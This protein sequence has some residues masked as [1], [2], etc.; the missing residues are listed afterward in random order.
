M[1]KGLFLLLS[2][3]FLVGQVLAQ[4]RTINGRVTSADDGQPVIGAT[5]IV[6]GT[7]TG[8]VTNP[9]GAYSI[10]LPDGSAAVLV[11]KS[12]G[13]KELEAKV[14]NS[15]TLNVV[16][17]LDVT[18]LNEQV[19]TANAIRR[20]KSSLGYAAPTVKAEEI[21]QGRATS[22]LSALT[23][24]VAG[25]N[26]TNT[27]GAPGSSSRIV[28]RG[29]S[30]VAG[31]NQALIVV[32]GIPVDNSSVTGGPNNLSSIDF[33]NR[34][35]DINPDDIESMTVL[36]GPAAAALYGSRASNG[37]VIITTKS[38]KKG[39]KKS[40][41]TV[42]STATF[43]NILKLPDFQ[44]EYGQGSDGD[45][46]PK[47]NF[48]WGPKFDG[49][50]KPWGQEID[51]E[52][53]TKP[54][55]AQKNN[56][57]K[58]FELGRAFNNNVSVSGGGEKTTYFLALSS[59]NSDGV[60]PGSSDTYNKYGIRFN[61]SAELSNNFKT[62]VSINYNKINSNMVQG[63]QG[64]GSVYNNLLQTPRD[65]PIDQMGDLNNKFYSY[66]SYVDKNGILRNNRYGYY[67]AYTTSPYYILQN[68]KNLNDVDRVFGN[69]TLTYDPLKWLNVVERV[70]ADVYADRRRFKYPKF[71]LSP[72]DETS[73]NYSQVSNQRNQVG[74]YEE[75]NFNVSEIVHDL[76]I[77][78]KKDFGKDFHASLMVGNN[79]RQ[80][81]TTSLN[82]ATN[83]TGGLVVPEW[84]NL[85]NSNGPV[86]ST[87]NYTI[88]R[89]VGLYSELN[90]DYKSMLFLGVSARNDWSST[91][92]KANNSF[93]YPSVNAS[94]VFSE[95]FQGTS[96]ANVLNFG[97]VRASWAQ[98]GADA[99]PYLLTT[100]FNRT[101]IQSG[102]GNTT[103]PFNGVPGLTLGG[104]IGNP[105][106]KP[107]ITTAFEVGTELNFLDNRISVDFSYYENKSKNQILA[108]PIAEASGFTSKV[109]NAGT[110]QNKGVEL[111]LRGVPVRTSYGLN[112][113]VYGT[114]TR[115]VNKVLSLLD[116]ISQIS[117][118]G[119]TTMSVV[120]AVGQPYGSFFSTDVQRDDQG[121]VIVDPNSGLPLKTSSG[122][123][124][125][126]YNPK[127]QASWGTNIT[128]K[129]WSLNVLFDTKQGG[130][131]F[132][133]TKN[134]TAFNGTSAITGGNRDP[135]I[136]PNSVYKDASGKIVVNTD[137][138]FSPQ[139][140]YN[141]LPDGQNVV[142]A[143]YVKL[144]EASLSYRLPKHT[145]NRTP[146]GDITVGIFGNNLFLWAAKENKF[147]DPEV[148]SAGAGNLQGFDFTAQPSLR[149]FGVNVKVSF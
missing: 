142:D 44:N 120:A 94:F 113:E 115:N 62:A 117:L 85:A 141:A 139:A 80:R 76:M 51:G 92:P 90:V 35:N 49:Q 60:M 83:A 125:G 42:N 138:N 34:G 52:R 58:F 74:S 4:S 40:E 145:L 122:V 48:S 93:F 23:G 9:D 17:Y 127:Y 63:G 111:A 47:E 82:S 38:G 5:V 84:Y 10:K 105:D 86:N 41:I 88:R 75:N 2:A 67:G 61:G 19:I 146:F 57:R 81:Q 50:T 91:L 137:K 109:V 3:L 31:S 108:I 68:Y 30:S 37:A 22:A 71:N 148:N 121:R 29:G 11:F 140:Y 79:I 6:K 59:L 102:F 24:K 64:P 134:I 12:V 70:G 136:F 95:L 66:G 25:V 106:L 107:E 100:T 43:S 18:K 26:I 98:V 15:N 135:Q 132:S 103:F 129:G 72:A 101:I 114:Y 99:D 69:F 112:I 149:N 1:R 13:L 33:G 131:F 87:N 65:I 54:Y 89:L 53:L 126:S 55:S 73:G 144:R 123:F 20:D 116:G 77:T 130:K 27:A 96:F 39:A 14:G 104:T 128:Y 133:R 21:T 118:G 147:A 7:S 97:K 16:M 124:L 110:I 46:D 28:L 119:L 36:K 78:A 8:A 143:S 32:D 45:Y 56:I